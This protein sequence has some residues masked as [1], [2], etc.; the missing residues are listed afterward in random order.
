VLSQQ[1]LCGARANGAVF[2]KPCQA[3]GAKKVSA[4]GIGFKRRQGDMK[5][6]VIRDEN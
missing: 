3:K 6:R 5:Q 2:R 1:H 4:L